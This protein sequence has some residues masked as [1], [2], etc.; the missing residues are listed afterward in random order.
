MSN[1]H[2]DF[3]FN[4]LNEAKDFNELTLIKDKRKFYLLFI[5]LI[6]IINKVNKYL[7]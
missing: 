7:S 5:L 1:E 2:I 4:F 3:K 6:K